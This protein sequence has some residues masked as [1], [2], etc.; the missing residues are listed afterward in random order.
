ASQRKTRKSPFCSTNSQLPTP[1]SPTQMQNLLTWARR[2]LSE[3]FRSQP[4]RMHLAMAEEL[5][6]L[7]ENRGTRLNILGPRGGAKSTVCTLAYVLQVACEK[8]EP[9]IWIVSDTCQQ[10]LIHLE[11]VKEELLENEAIEES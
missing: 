1:N 8:R 6:R 3:H 9:Y 4:S 2:I 7:A 5:G 11:N 10:A